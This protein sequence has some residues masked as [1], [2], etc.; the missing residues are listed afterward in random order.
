MNH[1][2]HEAEIAAFKVRQEGDDKL[3]PLKKHEHELREKLDEGKTLN[4]VGVN[5]RN[6][7]K[8]N[9]EVTKTTEEVTK[10]TNEV[11]KE[12]TADEKKSA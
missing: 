7:K 12:E 8:A 10:A 11:A 2:L 4:D 1:N 3:K 5:T 6:L 9:K